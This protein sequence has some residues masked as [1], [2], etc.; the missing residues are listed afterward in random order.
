MKSTFACFLIS[1]FMF[2]SNVSAG[3]IIG[4]TR[5]I[6]SGSKKEVSLSV[7]NPDSS[8]YLIQ[9]WV[10]EL[11]N[12][13]APFIIT[14]PLYRLDGKQQNIMRIV[15]VGGNLP[16]DRESMFWLNIKS[17]P[18]AAQQKNVLQIAVKNR[19][20][21]I[22]RPEAIDDKSAIEAAG[23][24]KWSNQ[25]NRLSVRNSSPYYINF[26]SITVKGKNI[27]EPQWVAPFSSRDYVL[28][29]SAAGPVTWKIINDYGAVSK[30]WNAN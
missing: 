2:V 22:F 30:A 25:G 6:F 3:V 13:K 29:E 10:D 21:L 4:G 26:Q 8:P 7:D 15:R 17:I 27:P 5:V 23:K 16:T 18:Q 12:A 1:L 19:I 14:P 9:S 28:K 20:K 11:N 24:L